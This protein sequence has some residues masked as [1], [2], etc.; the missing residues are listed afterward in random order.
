MH[1][2][3]IDDYVYLNKYI[4]LDNAYFSYA[5]FNVLSNVMENKDYGI[6]QAYIFCNDNVRETGRL[7]YLP[8]YM[9]MFLERQT[10]INIVYKVDLSGLQ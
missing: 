8:I 4:Y 5:I 7:L 9:V 10:P 2:G 6:E 1:F 3:S